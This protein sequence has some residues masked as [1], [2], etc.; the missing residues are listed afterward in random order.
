MLKRWLDALEEYAGWTSVRNAGILPLGTAWD[1]PWR[2]GKVPDVSLSGNFFLAKYGVP[3]LIQ[4]GGGALIFTASE[5]DWSGRRRLRL[6]FQ[7]RADQ[8]G[9]CP[10]VDCAPHNIRVNC[11]ALT[12]RPPLSMQGFQQQRPKG[13][14]AGSA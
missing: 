8:H 12:D 4:S 14:R 5:L 2:P 9:S 6:R 3:A 11:L 10:G 1:T 13:C 7:R